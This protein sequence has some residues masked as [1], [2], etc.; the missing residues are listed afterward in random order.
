MKSQ[1]QIAKLHKD[2]TKIANVIPISLMN[3]DTKILKKILTNLIQEHI[4]EIIHKD[5]IG[6]GRDLFGLSQGPQRTLHTL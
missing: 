4:K 3:I 2:S 5:Q 1:S 6:F